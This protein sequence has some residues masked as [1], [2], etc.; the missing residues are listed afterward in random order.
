[1][2]YKNKSELMISILTERQ[3]LETKVAGLTP[4]E[5]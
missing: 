1:M 3:K 5:M 2:R 4:A